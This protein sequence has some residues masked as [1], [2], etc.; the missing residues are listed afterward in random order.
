MFYSKLGITLA[1]KIHDNKLKLLGKLTASLSHEIKNPLS[2]LKLNLD[3]LKMGEEEFDAETNECID[4]SLESVDLINKLI[5][6]TLEFSRKNK[7][8]FE[9]QQ[10]NEIIYKAISITKGSAVKKSV[11]FL[12]NL[13]PSLQEIEINETKILQVIVNLIT[14]AIEA[15]ENKGQIIVNSE[16]EDNHIIIEVI[17]EGCGIS[18]EDK[19][20]IFSEFYTSKEEGTGLGLNVCK[21]ILDEHEAEI[22]VVDNATKGSN[23]TVKFP[24]Y[25][26]EEK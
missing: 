14:N 4:A 3:F 2:V 12:L 25:I 9:L 1:D 10:V 13:N 21:D 20:K 8:G 24:I 17:D 16:I 22:F 11:N 15:S 6:N 23:F 18:N 19:E 5:Q 7:G 26:T